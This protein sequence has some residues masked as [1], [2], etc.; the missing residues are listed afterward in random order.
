MKIM[1]ATFIGITSLFAVA[2]LGGWH[3][4]AQPTV[5]R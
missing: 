5:K 2:L 4:D 1:S 3:G